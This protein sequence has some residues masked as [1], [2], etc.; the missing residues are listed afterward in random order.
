MLQK[1]ICKTK[2]NNLALIL[3]CV[4]QSIKKKMKLPTF[5]LLIIYT[6]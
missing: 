2:G 6:S 4:I 1:R 5:C 3:T